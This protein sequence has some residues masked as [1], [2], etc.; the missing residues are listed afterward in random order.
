[1]PA[2]VLAVGLNGLGAVRSLGVR[3]VTVYAVCSSN[4]RSILRSR[5][6]AGS[7]IVPTGDDYET[8]LF[9]FLISEYP[10][11][12][13]LVPTTDQTA[14]FLQNYKSTLVENGFRFLIPPDDTTRVLNDKRLEIEFIESLEVP[15]PKSITR[16][17]TDN[18]TQS[19][20]FPVIVKPRRFDGYKVINAKNVIIKDKNG[21]IEFLD[22]Y[23]DNLD[24]FI[25]QEIISGDDE[26]LWVCN[27]LF[28]QNSELVSCFTF[29]RLGTSP[30]HYGVTT[31]AIGTHNPRVKDLVNLI[32]KQ[33]GYIGPAM[34]EFKQDEFS[35]E[36]QYI[37][38]NP[39]LGMCNW[40]DTQSD[41]NNVYNYYQLALGFQVSNAGTNAGQLER[42]YLNFFSDLYARVEDRQ[43]FFSILL[44][45][46]RILVKRP[47]FAM[48]YMR[49]LRPGIIGISGGIAMGY[50]R[51]RKRL[52]K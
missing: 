23:S 31:S 42:G 10:G 6:L 35:G 44:V 3:G 2:I 19:L 43:S 16:L 34:F 15:C 47:V 27:C 18:L 17:S 7:H 51:L 29:N 36:Y 37:E 41:V 11:G 20:S 45:F 9:Q 25:A 46:I 4:D 38:I 30:S 26:N 39:R 48:F 52:G 12:G 5:Y 24:L 22:K 21:A 14:E 50:R 40:F 33:I 28:D 1:M 8:R 13:V 32:G 49:D